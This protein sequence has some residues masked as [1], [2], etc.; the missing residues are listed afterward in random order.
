MNPKEKEK[1]L[2]LMEIENEWEERALLQKNEYM[3][4]KQNERTITKG[5][6]LVI[7]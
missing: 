2:S 6:E 7:H 5:T 3:T 4:Q 1:Q